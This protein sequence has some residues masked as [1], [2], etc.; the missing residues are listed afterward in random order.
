MLGV[1]TFGS[2]Q[3]LE[4]SGELERRAGHS[5]T[6]VRSLAFFVRN[7]FLGQD[8]TRCRTRLQK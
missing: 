3:A 6:R 7:L 1:G 5:D 2:A 8:R 4:M